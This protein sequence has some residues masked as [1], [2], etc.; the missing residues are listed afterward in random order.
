VE[1]AVGGRIAGTGAGGSRRSAETAAAAAALR[2][3]A[4]G[5]PDTPLAGPSAARA[6]SD[7]PAPA[8]R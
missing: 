2:T 6:P 3:L 5:Q 1:V 4:A 7:P 8:D